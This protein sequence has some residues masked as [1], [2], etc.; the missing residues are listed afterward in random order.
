MKR[1]QLRTTWRKYNN[2]KGLA[3]LTS[4]SYRKI[5]DF[6]DKLISIKKIDV[7]EKVC[8]QA[9]NKIYFNKSTKKVEKKKVHYYGRKIS[10]YNIRT[11][12]L[13][14]MHRRGILLETSTNMP[15]NEIIKKLREFQGI[16]NNHI[17]VTSIR[18]E[19]Y[20]SMLLHF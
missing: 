9:E 2:S 19:S 12:H 4:S 16:I 5:K 13:Q 20:A 1:K 15:R 8:P 7:G 10:L 18:S 6:R 3:V 11:K 17:L 14:L